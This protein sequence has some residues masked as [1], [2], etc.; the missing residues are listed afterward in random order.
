MKLRTLFGVFLCTCLA[1]GCRTINERLTEYRAHEAEIAEFHGR[2][3]F[4]GHA[5]AGFLALE[6]RDY[7]A[8][9]CH[10]LRAYRNT[11]VPLVGP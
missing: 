4:W 7:A 9:Q 6:K 8:A 1:T 10:Y 5:N 11:G 3:E 2:T